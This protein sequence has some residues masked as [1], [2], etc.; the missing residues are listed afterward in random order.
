MAPS[1]A[2]HPAPSPAAPPLARPPTPTPT[3][4]GPV[5]PAGL[6]RLSAHAYRAGSYTPLDLALNPFWEAVT[7]CFP[8]WLAPNAVTLAGTVCMLATLP[9]AAFASPCAEGGAP[10]LPPWAHACIVAAL[11]AYQTLDACD[12][13]QA[14][15][16]GS[17]SPLGQLFDHG[18]DA[19]VGAVVAWN[20]ML[21][22]GAGL[23]GGSSVARTAPGALTLQLGLFA[24]GLA[25]WE[26]ASTRVLRTNVHGFGVSEMQLTAMAVHTAAGAVGAAGACGVWARAAPVLPFGWAP[27]DAV[28]A[29]SA[30]LFA[31]SAASFVHTVAVA[32]AAPARL[33]EQVGPLALLLAGC[34]F[35]APAMRATLQL[36]DTR[37]GAL[38]LALALA[39]TLHTTRTI[40]GAMAHE[41]VRWAHQ[42]PALAALV[43]LVP[44]AALGGPR[45]ADLALGLYTGA[46]GAAYA[47]YVVA[48]VRQI[49]AHLG[50]QVFRVKGFAV[51][52]AGAAGGAGVAA[53]VEAKAALAASRAADASAQEEPRP[54]RSGRAGTPA[55]AASAARRPS[56][57][58]RARSRVKQ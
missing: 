50:V 46:V 11:F 15:R 8:L 3:P 27:A 52:G 47:A 24:L 42:A 26:E 38:A 22:V 55:R 28:L 41:P 12:G 18:C 40:V 44:A 37:P 34:A 31:L 30:T 13:K 43:L 16:T 5:T 14:R 39:Q 17:S 9:L 21:A 49:A 23:V 7:S 2:L 58:G 33:R 25:P 1:A 32:R 36:G 48:A 4:V 20:F 10:T 51:G 56:V 6:A 54:P 29:L 19:L 53:K 45:D 57:G 35:F